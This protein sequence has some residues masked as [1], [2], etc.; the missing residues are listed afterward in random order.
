MGGVIPILSANG[1]PLAR[2]AG[3]DDMAGAIGF[4][5]ETRVEDIVRAAPILP[6]M[7]RAGFVRMGCGVESPSRAT[8][9]ELGKGINLS[10]VDRAAELVAAAAKAGRHMF[11]EKPLALSLDE[12]E[13]ITLMSITFYHHHIIFSRCYDDIKSSALFS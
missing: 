5:V 6:T 10:L 13:L 2:I 12:L 3:A 1:R 11:V 7:R 9:Q 4:I 8:H